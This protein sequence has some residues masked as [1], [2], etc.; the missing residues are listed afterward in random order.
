MKT[1]VIGYGADV[2]M[3]DALR[4]TLAEADQAICCSAFVNRAGVHLVEPQLAALGTSARVV[5][6]SAFGG[7]STATAMSALQDTG[8]RLRVVNPARGTFH[9]KLFVARTGG[10]CRALIGSANLTSG[11]VTNIEVGVLLEGRPD[12]PQLDTAWT[13]AR[14]LWEHD[15]ARA[16]GSPWQ[17]SNPTNSSPPTCCVNCRRRSPPIQSS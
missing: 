2:G 12:D 11:L 6:T 4:Q 13:V 17:R 15:A 14:R 7:P 10:T 3:L 1:S 9:P 5:V 8:A 16:R